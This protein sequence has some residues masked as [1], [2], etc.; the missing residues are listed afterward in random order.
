[1]LQ[2]DVSSYEHRHMYD[3]LTR[4]M[5]TPQTSAISMS[6]QQLMSVAQEHGV[7]KS[8]CQAHYRQM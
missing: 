8:F 5:W 2:I 7:P 6:E 3:C 4:G 1:M